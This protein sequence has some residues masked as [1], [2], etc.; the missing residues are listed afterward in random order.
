MQNCGE[1]IEEPWKKGRSSV[2]PC[3]GFFD[4][5]DLGSENKQNHVHYTQGYR[6]L[7]ENE[8]LKDQHW[9]PLNV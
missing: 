2:L 8:M 9:R 1:Q 3:G 4:L 6:V 5:R 7:L